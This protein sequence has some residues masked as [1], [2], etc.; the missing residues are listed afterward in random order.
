MP[1]TKLLLPRLILAMV[2]IALFGAQWL[3]GEFPVWF[4]AMPMNLLLG[5]LWLAVIWEGY[6]RRSSSLYGSLRLF[7]NLLSQ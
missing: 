7:S 5:A 6:R 2:A 4:F 1:T 3:I